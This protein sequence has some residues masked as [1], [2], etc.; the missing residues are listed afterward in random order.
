VEAAEAPLTSAARATRR[1]FVSNTRTGQQFLVDSG[2]EISVLPPTAGARLASDIVLTA[3]NGTRIKT[4]GPKTLRL[5]LGVKPTYA[6]TFEMADV[7]RPI[8]GADFLHYFGLLIDVKNNRLIDPSD[9]NV[10]QTISVDDVSAPALVV[11]HTH[12]WTKLLQTEGYNNPESICPD[13][14]TTERIYPDRIL[15][16]SKKHNPYF[17]GTYSSGKYLYGTYMSGM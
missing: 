14:I 6:W 4:Y 17:N 11:S 2:A 16:E 7:A 8:I 10:I 5:C 15:T 12:K 1:V 13:R 3:A 9:Q